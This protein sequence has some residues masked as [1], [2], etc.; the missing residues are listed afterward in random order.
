LRL[1]ID[2]RALNKVIVRNTYP[3]PLIADLFDQLSGAKYFTKLDLRSGYYQVRIAD[4]DEPKTTCV[5]RYGAFEFRVMPFGLT[6]A[7]ATFCTL[8]NQVFHE[9]LDKFVVV[10]LDDIVVYSASIEEHQEHLAQVFSEVEREPAICE[11]REV[12]VRTG[13]HQVLRPRGGTWPYSY[14]SGE[15]EGNPGMESPHK[16]ERYWNITF[17]ETIKTYDFEQNVNEE[18]LYK[19]IILLIGNNV[20]TLSI[21]K[22]WSAEKFQMK[23]MESENVFDMYYAPEAPEAPASKKKASKW[24][25]GESSKA[26]PA[27]KTRTAD[28][29]TDVPSTNA[30]PPPSPLD[31]QTLPAPAGSTPSPL[32][33][34]DKTQQAAPAST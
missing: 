8:M 24:H 21:V 25:H 7:P 11:A 27:K 5:T 26:P 32:A 23:D 4:G 34:A 30:T 3:I 33:P 17:D 13:E 9:Y 2:Y 31:Q 29:P 20:E 15:G 28:P 14:G 1:C 12:L 19:H 22:T 16:R 6:N 18:F 10:Y